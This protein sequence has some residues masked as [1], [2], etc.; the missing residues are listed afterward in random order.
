MDCLRPTGLGRTV[1]SLYAVI[2]GRGFHMRILGILS[3]S[4]GRGGLPRHLVCVFFS[5]SLFFTYRQSMTCFVFYCLV[6]LDHPLLN[7]VWKERI[8]RILDIEDRRYSIFI[9]PDLLASFS[10]GPE[11]NTAVRALIKANKKHNFFF[12]TLFLLKKK[13]KKLVL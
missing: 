5:N 11:P 2:T 9:E 6:V 4:V 10:F 12:F 1:T 13:K 3:K 7:S 8:L